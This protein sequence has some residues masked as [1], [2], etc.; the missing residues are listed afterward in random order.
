[1][2]TKEWLN[3]GRDLDKEIN[4]LMQARREAFSACTSTT[5][6]N[7]HDIIKT[8]K[9][10]NA[11]LERLAEVNRQIDCRIDELLGIKQEILAAISKVDSTT[12]RAILTER[13]VNLKKWERIA[14]D[15]GYDYYWVLRLHGRALREI[16]THH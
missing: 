12:Y 16:E 5:S 9:N 8:D 10:P 7:K 4:A 1:M 11:K 3:R 2:T 15:L 13:Y 6:K 14:I